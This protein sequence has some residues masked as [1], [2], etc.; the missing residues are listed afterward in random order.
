MAG[1]PFAKLNDNRAMKLIHVRGHPRI[2]L[3]RLKLHKGEGSAAG[4]RYLKGIALRRL[5]VS[6]SLAA[7]VK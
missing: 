4:W 5:A 2:G 7:V 3:I 6:L 1:S